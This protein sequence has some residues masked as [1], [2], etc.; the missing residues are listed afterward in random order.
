[1][2]LRAEEVTPISTISSLNLKD[3]ETSTLTELCYIINDRLVIESPSIVEDKIQGWT[4]DIRE[5][6]LNSEGPMKGEGASP[7]EAVKQL[8]DNIK[9]RQLKRNVKSSS[10]YTVK[11]IYNV[12]NSLQL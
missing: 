9:G 12:P 11:V 4:A 10:G 6:S 7:E 3:S 8:I 2:N 1:M 5:C